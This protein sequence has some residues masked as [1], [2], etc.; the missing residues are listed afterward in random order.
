M[1][2]LTIEFSNNLSN[3][4]TT[5]VI[6]NLGSGP[7]QG[8]IRGFKSK[9][10]EKFFRGI[11][12]PDQPLINYWYYLK[13]S[14]G[15]VPRDFIISGPDQGLKYQISWFGIRFLES[16]SDSD[17]WAISGPDQGLN[18][19]ISWFGIRPRIFS[20]FRL[21]SGAEISDFPGQNQVL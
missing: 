5:L 18:F 10:Q 17:F 11:S 9:T 19:R 7:D 1:R 8:L 12:G 4:N 20:N 16:G 2:N 13:Y 21:W 3:S 14:P 6:F 15:S